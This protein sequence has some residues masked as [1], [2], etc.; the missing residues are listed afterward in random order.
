[1]KNWNVPGNGFHMSQNLDMGQ[2]TNIR[3]IEVF[4][5]SLTPSDHI[6]VNLGQDTYWETLYLSKWMPVAE[7]EAAESF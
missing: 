5:P 4:G 7:L 2:K 1:M 6:W 3:K